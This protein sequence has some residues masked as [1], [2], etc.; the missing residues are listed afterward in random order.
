[1]QNVEKYTLTYLTEYE[2]QYKKYLEDN[3]HKDI[4]FP[5]VELKFNK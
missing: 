3:K 4:D 5:N 1:M 2:I